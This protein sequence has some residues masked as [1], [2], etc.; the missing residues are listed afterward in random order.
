MVLNLRIKYQYRYGTF[1]FNVLLLAVPHSFHLFVTHPC[2][3]K[4]KAKSIVQL[5]LNSM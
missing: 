5:P 4:Y 3:Y 1:L 2:R